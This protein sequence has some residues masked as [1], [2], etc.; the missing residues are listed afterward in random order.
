M[1]FLDFVDGKVRQQIWTQDSAKAYVLSSYADAEGSGENKV[2]ERALA[3]ADDPKLKRMIAKHSAD[4]VR[5]E[6]MLTDRREALGLPLHR[7]PARMKTID[8]LSDEAGGVLDLPMDCDAHIAEVYALLL[9]IEE[10]ALTE[11]PKSA[12]IARLVGDEQ[13]A[14]IFDEIAA[15]EALHLKYCWAVGTRYGGE[16]FEA[17][18]DELRLLE[19]RVYGRNSRNIALH[20]LNEG[21]LKLPPLIEVAL[22]S[23]VGMG[24]AFDLSRPTSVAA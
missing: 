17:R 3:R 5:H 14:A 22:R 16:G 12:R 9:V 23:L 13:T 18:V 20:L 7:V 4:E 19:A 15:D 21:L 8:L 2:F 10:R 24:E 6:A 11:F 1:S